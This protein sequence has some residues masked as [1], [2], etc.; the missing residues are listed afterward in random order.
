VY[1]LNSLFGS[2]VGVIFW[3]LIG[4]GLLLIARGLYMWYTGMDAL[5]NEVRLL[6]KTLEERL[7]APPSVAPPAQPAPPVRRSPLPNPFT[8]KPF[9]D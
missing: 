2:A 7:P 9:P 8:S 1:E 6:R 3:I 5:L 4:L